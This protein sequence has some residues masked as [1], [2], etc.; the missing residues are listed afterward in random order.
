[1]KALHIA[2]YQEIHLSNSHH[3]MN[4]LRP[5]GLKKDEEQQD[6]QGVQSLPQ[7]LEV[8]SKS[9]TQSEEDQS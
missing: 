3:P 5:S 7:A 1:M 6:Q 4:L 8:R 9:E 2:H